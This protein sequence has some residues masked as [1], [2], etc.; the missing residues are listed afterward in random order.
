MTDPEQEDLEKKGKSYSVVLLNRSFQWVI[1]I[2]MLVGLIASF[3]YIHLGSV[4]VG[5]SVGMT[6]HDSV[7]AYC[8]QLK[9]YYTKSGLFKTLIFIGL[10]LFLLLAAPAFVLSAAIGY[11]VITLYNVTS[12]PIEK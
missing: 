6:F 4:L 12:R 11:G 9:D 1:A 3:F 5:L 10:I 8:I 7:Q 2:L